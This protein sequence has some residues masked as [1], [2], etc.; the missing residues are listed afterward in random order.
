[1]DNDQRHGGALVEARIRRYAPELIGVRLPRRAGHPIHHWRP[2]MKFDFWIRWGMNLSDADFKVAWLALPLPLAP[3]ANRLPP[4]VTWR[5]R[6]PPPPRRTMGW[7][8][9]ATR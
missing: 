9:R 6:G 5:G 7:R 2:T 3:P 4:R 8:L 1:M